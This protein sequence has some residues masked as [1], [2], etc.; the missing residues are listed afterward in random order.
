MKNSAVKK[1]RHEIDM[2]AR[3]NV[4]EHEQITIPICPICSEAKTG[5]FP[6]HMKS[7]VQYG[8]NPKALAIALNTVGT[9]SYNRTHNVLSS[10]F[11]LS[12]KVVEK[13]FDILQFIPIIHQVI[14]L[15]AYI[16]LKE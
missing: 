16:W 12:P 13:L 14:I 5:T 7:V 4:T 10:V 2:I 1:T 11:R 9:V 8:Q 3:V 15:R 6:T